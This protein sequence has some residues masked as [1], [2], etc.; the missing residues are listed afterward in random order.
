MKEMSL[1]EMATYS[2]VLIKCEY[3]NGMAGSGTGFIMNLCQDD[4]KHIPVIV[5]NNH[6]IKDSIKTTFDFCVADSNGLPINRKIFTFTYEG[7]GN[8][9]ISHPNKDI[10]L[11]CL[12]LGPALNE[13]SKNGIEI[14]YIPL[15]TNM[16]PSFE[17]LN[18][19]SAME[20]VVMVGYP[21]GLSDQYN[22]KPIIRRGITATH[23]KNDYQGKKHFLVDMACFPGSS[24][25]PIF[26][27]NEGSYTFGNTLYAGN[28][29]FFVGILFGGPQFTAQG[30]L[31]FASLPNMPHTITNIPTNLG[32]AIKSREIL[33]LE[34]IINPNGG[35]K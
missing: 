19:F 16:I 27:L 1:S 21:I 13:L 29:I 18:Q 34:K 4:E 23:L 8:N 17:Q 30:N 15:L 24:G 6:V 25:S 5:T 11:C 31:Q 33:E 2:T 12:L 3:S 9:W 14:F 10:D 35:V 22:H 7:K 26:I 28:R 32:I 20:D